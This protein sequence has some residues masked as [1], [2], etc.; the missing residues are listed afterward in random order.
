MLED[1]FLTIEARFSQP[2]LEN[3][4]TNVEARLLNLESSL[5]ARLSDLEGRVQSL[6]AQGEVLA[7]RGQHV[8]D[9]SA[10]LV[11]EQERLAERVDL[12]QVQSTN[13]QQEVTSQLSR[14]SQQLA[15]LAQQVQ[16][17]GV[18]RGAPAQEDTDSRTTDIRSASTPSAT[19]TT[20]SRADNGQGV[21]GLGALPATL[22]L[23]PA[24]ITCSQRE[25]SD[26]FS[27]MQLG[28]DHNPLQGE[29]R[30]IA[31]E[32]RPTTA[33]P[34]PIPH[35]GRVTGERINTIGVEGVGGGG[36]SVPLN[37]LFSTGLGLLDPK[38]RDLVART[39][40]LPKFSGEGQEWSDF[41]ES[42]QRWWRLS[43][44]P[45][46]YKHEIFKETLPSATR[47]LMDKLIGKRNWGYTEMYDHLSQTYKG[48]DNRFTARAKWEGLAPPQKM[49]V[50]TFKHWY[51]TWILY[52][53][54]VPSITFQQ[55][56]DQFLKVMPDQW[57]RKI[58]RQSRKE[59][60]KRKQGEPR[61]GTHTDLQ[62]FVLD[63]LADI[64]FADMIQDT[65]HRETGDTKKKA[66]SEKEPV[67]AVVDQVTTCRHCGVKGHSDTKCWKKHPHLR[68]PP[69]T[70]QKGKEAD[71]RSKTRPPP[72][73]F[74]PHEENL[75]KQK[76][77]FWCEKEGHRVSE[78]PAKQAL[79]KRE[80]NQP[81]KK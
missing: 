25:A 81:A 36:S 33:I 19:R 58:A 70:E 27:R 72:R 12:H 10:D 77:C 38:V 9:V 17:Q 47:G 52:A 49:S 6:E 56:S 66:G 57:K 46:A 79:Q 5:E 51:E 21:S 54:S 80:G 64:E 22:C 18:P 68:P 23:D 7:N 14:V 32:E 13:L 44:L 4:I 59:D 3:T 65:Y 20:E 60:N 50:L 73:Q 37:P 63:E 29:V 31:E 35:H 11:E 40:P 1:Y 48:W 53:S 71:P 24:Q 16:S 26:P 34:F 45:D 67:S 78:C 74:T 62:A 42:W 75:Y 8:V 41:I 43:G 2:Q 55:L 15:E 30:A 39:V 69:K 61:W 28:E 76:K